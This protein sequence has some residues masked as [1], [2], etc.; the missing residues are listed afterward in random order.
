MNERVPPHAACGLYTLLAADEQDFNRNVPRGKYPYAVRGKMI[1]AWRVVWRIMAV[2]RFAVH[3][4]DRYRDER[5]GG[6][7]APLASR[8]LPVLTGVAL[9]LLLA[10]GLG[11]GAEISLSDQGEG[12]DYLSGA[13]IKLPAAMMAT[14]LFG[15]GVRVITNRKHTAQAAAFDASGAL[16]RSASAAPG[17]F[18]PYLVGQPYVWFLQEVR[19]YTN[20]CCT[21]T[22]HGPATFYL[23]VD[24]RVNDF[25][26]LSSLD[27]PT[28]G[29]PDTEWIPRDGWQRVNT[30]ISP[31]V[32]GTNRA[33]YVSIFEGGVGIGAVDQFYAVYSKT[34]TNAG[35]IRLRTQYEGNMYCVVIATNKSSAAVSAP[36]QKPT[37]PRTK[38]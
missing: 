3:R 9:V 20:Y 36:V 19:H 34:M 5:K 16:S 6:Q 2:N 33:D 10:I 15:P 35:S 37:A 24:N 18:P 11:V 31:K 30:G 21:V 22:V 29:P 14:N 4:M 38:G 26:E 13:P 27:D 23:L 28:F 1:R 12:C 17:V 8:R 7:K 25:G 32:G